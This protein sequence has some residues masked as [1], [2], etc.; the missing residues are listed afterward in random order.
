M[1]GLTLLLPHGWEGLGPEHSSARLERFL[2]LC[3][4]E[5]MQV[6]NLTTPAQ[7]FHLLRRQIKAPF[8]KPL[9]LMTPKSLL[10]HPTA[11]SALKDL[12]QGQFSPVIDD[13]DATASTK[14]VI[15]CSGKIYYQLITRRLPLPGAN[16]AELVSWHLAT[17]DQRLRHSHRP[18]GDALPVSSK[19][20]RGGHQTI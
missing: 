8:R 16:L 10:R 14:K 1:C 15:F 7:Y 9:I 2:Q 5:N 18:R 17:S 6:G 20:P 19:G 4:N 11:V 12:S 3:A 13:A